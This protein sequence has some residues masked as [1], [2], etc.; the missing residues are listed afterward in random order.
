MRHANISTSA[1]VHPPSARNLRPFPIFGRH[2]ASPRGP[3]LRE[4]RIVR[5]VSRQHRLQKPVQPL[6]ILQRQ[7][8]PR[9]IRIQRT[10]NCLSRRLGKILPIQLLLQRRQPRPRQRHLIRPHRLLIL[11]HR[12]AHQILD[13]PRHYILKAHCRSPFHRSRRRLRSRWSSGSNVVRRRWTQLPPLVPDN[14]RATPHATTTSTTCSNI[15]IRVLPLPRHR[16]D[17]QHSTSSPAPL[18]PP[19]S[20][21]LLPFYRG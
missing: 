19:I 12:P 14:R 8:Q 10:F 16:R 4:V 9:L 13:F 7:L 20:V 18:K 15:F 17:G 2:R 1:F 6:L 11:I 21:G 3:P 5:V